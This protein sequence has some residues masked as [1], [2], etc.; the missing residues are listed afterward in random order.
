MRTFSIIHTVIHLSS[1]HFHPIP[2]Y[3]QQPTPTTMPNGSVSPPILEG[4]EFDHCDQ[5]VGTPRSQSATSV[6][7]PLPSATPLP[8]PN[9]CKCDRSIEKPC[10]HL[11]PEQ[12][13]L[14]I[15]MLQY[16]ERAG[17]LNET[18][19]KQCLENTLAPFVLKKSQGRTKHKKEGNSSRHQRDPM[20]LSCS[21]VQTTFSSPGQTA[22]SQ[23]SGTSTAL[24][25]DTLPNEVE[26]PSEQ[27][28]L[29]MLYRILMVYNNCL[30]I[31]SVI[32]AM[33]QN[34]EHLEEKVL[35]M[36]IAARP[37]FWKVM[38][39]L[40]LH[41]HIDPREGDHENSQVILCVARVG[42]VIWITWGLFDGSFL[43][44]LFLLVTCIGA[45]KWAFVMEKRDAEEW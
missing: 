19:V 22:T 26:F 16:L 38:D 40:F 25:T 24:A 39:F 7:G 12:L 15:C 14:R 36:W 37:T 33:A 10:P 44:K 21:G 3:S 23:S 8:E 43:G 27:L 35:T 11:T 5:P 34:R 42:C 4:S 41:C 9:F 17:S 31:F 13:D 30:A 28:R 1:L 29:W 18:V 6:T 32:L 45:L 20:G 2:T